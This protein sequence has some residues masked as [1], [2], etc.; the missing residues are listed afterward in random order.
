[1]IS[2]ESI[3][4]KKTEYFKHYFCEL[5]KEQDNRGDII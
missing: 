2:Y 1:M 4:L 3:D 5:Y